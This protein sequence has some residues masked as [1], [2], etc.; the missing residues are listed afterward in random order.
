MLESDWFITRGRPLIIAHRGASAVAPQ[1]TLA[2]FRRAAE[3]GADGV[4][5]DVHLSADG[6][7][8]VIHNFDVDGLTDGI[9]KVT[10][11]TLAELKE[12]DAGEKFAPQFAGERIPT[13][14]EVLEALEGKLLVNVELK[15]VSPAG[16]GLEEPVAEVVRQHGMESKVL[17]SSFNPFTLRRMRPLAPNIPSGLLYAHDLPTYLRRAWLGPFTPHEARHPDAEMTDARL[18]KW[19]HA[20]KLRINV[21]TVDD[22]A[23]MKRLIALG[24]DGI[25]TN[26]PDVL[27]QSLVTGGLWYTRPSRI[28]SDYRQS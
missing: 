12:L 23:E 18:V 3:L 14:A 13:L 17:F 9:G 2:A 6:V 22:P 8:V 1:N 11:K 28:E 21:W 19:C 7:P 5:L 20:R 27:G 10:D 15:D 24:V 26:K 16:V 25:I 4:E